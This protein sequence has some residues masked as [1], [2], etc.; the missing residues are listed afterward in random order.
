MRKGGRH[1]NA[2]QVASFD[3]HSNMVELLLSK[4]TDVNA[5]GGRYSNALQA[6]LGGELLVIIQ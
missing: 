6:G 5:Q 1:G 3:G 2:L 4:G